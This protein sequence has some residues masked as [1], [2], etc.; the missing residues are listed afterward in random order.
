M[1]FWSADWF[2]VERVL[3]P[4]HQRSRLLTGKACSRRGLCQSQGRTPLG[5]PLHSTM[6]RHVQGRSATH[7]SGR[8]IDLIT[9]AVLECCDA[10][11][12]T[13]LGGTGCIVGGS[14]GRA[15]VTLG[16]AL[17]S[18]KGIHRTGHAGHIHA[19]KR[20]QASPA[21]QNALAGARSAG[22]ALLTDTTLF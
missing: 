8:S 2:S 11:L 6:F 22:T 3:L 13:A 15:S 7:L 9:S 16:G 4:R 1:Q 17:S 10:L 12:L 21:K 19:A 18:G 5:S 20:S 14:L